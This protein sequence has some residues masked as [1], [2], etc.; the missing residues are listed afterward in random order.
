MKTVLEN[1][2]WVKDNL[3]LGTGPV[4]VEP[5]TSTTFF[6]L[7]RERIFRRMWLNVA[8]DEDLPRNGDYIVKNIAVNKTS[9]LLVRGQDGKV[10]A[11]NNVC[12]HRGNRLAWEDKGHCH[13]MF[14]CRFHAWAYDRQGNLKHVSD[15]ANFYDLDKAT[16]GL[17]PI[18]ADVWAGFI[19]INLDPSPSETLFEYLGGLPD[20]LNGYPFA[21]QSRVFSFHID[22]QTNWKVLLDAQNEIYHLPFLH[23]R[24]F[25]VFGPRNAQHFTRTLAFKRFGR[26]TVYAVEEEQVEKPTAL[27]KIV[28]TLVP[29][30]GKLPEMIGWFDFYTVFPNFCILFLGHSYL[31]YNMWP[32]AVDRTH[33]EI[34]LYGPPVRNPAERFGLEYRV[35][36]LRDLWQED[37]S[38]HEEIQSSLNTGAISHFQ[39]QDEEIQIRHFHKV[40]RDEVARS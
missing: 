36:R 8:R 39:L 13:G 14:V 31:T 40:V 4:P 5:C 24:S 19:F 27:E 25:P 23:K 12:K 10:R 22:E 2:R 16:L 18:A 35:S 1:H 17:K 9:V 11:F 26:H 6:E 38:N 7:E 30:T 3:D 37:A 34:N 21:E 33:W 29:A 20:Q 28:D 15:E 32:E